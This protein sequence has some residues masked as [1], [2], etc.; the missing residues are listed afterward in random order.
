MHRLP[1]HPVSK[2]GRKI[3]RPMIVK[4]LTIQDKRMIYKSVKN[5]KANHDR[6]KTE[7]KPQPYV[8]LRQLPYLT[9]ISKPTKSTSTLLQRSMEAQAKNTLESR[10]WR[11]LFLRQRRKD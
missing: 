4:L 7:Q 6:L 3:H 2:F 8:C 11:A 5:L 1:Q 10:K 9:I